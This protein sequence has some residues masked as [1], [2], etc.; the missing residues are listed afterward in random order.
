MK[1]P[2]DVAWVLY[3]GVCGLC[4]RWVGWL[5]K[6]DRR[7]ALLFAP[8]QGLTAAQVRARHPELP[9]ADDTLLVVEA[10]GTPAERVRTL[11]DGALAT[12]ARLNG[13]WGVAAALLRL[14]PPPLRD[15]V[16]RA[17]ARRRHRWFGRL[18]ACRVPAAEERARF[19]P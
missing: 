1:P 18:A 17:V 6:R 4:D 10:P 13:F 7:R 8:L 19:L 9:A 11:S 16:Y 5:L 12:L 15:P 2:T 3:D 14:V